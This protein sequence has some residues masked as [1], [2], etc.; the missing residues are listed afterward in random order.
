MT[1]SCCPGF[2]TVLCVL[3]DLNKKQ[4][5]LENTHY[6]LLLLSIVGYTLIYVLKCFH[7]PSTAYCQWFFVIILIFWFL[8]CLPFSV[9]G[10][11]SFYF[12]SWNSFMSCSEL[13]FLFSDCIHLCLLHYLF[14]KPYSSVFTLAKISLMLCS[15]GILPVFL[16]SFSF[17]P[18][19]FS[20]TVCT[21]FSLFW[22]FSQPQQSSAFCI[23]SIL[24]SYIWAIYGVYFV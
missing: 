13:C 3:L 16:C 9:F 6:W 15:L 24:W 11:F 7:S 1:V 8:Q 17:L 10:C 4:A 14:S 5:Q 20:I 21:I 19:T 12:D 2:K 22:I 18:F 23:A